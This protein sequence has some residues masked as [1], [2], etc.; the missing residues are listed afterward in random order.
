MAGFAFK[1]TKTLRWALGLSLGV[2]L[3]VLGLVAGAAYRFDGPHGGA[4]RHMRDYGTPYVMALPEERRRAVF[5]DARKGRE[6]KSV[7]RAARRALYQEALTA[8]RAEPF[9]P[10]EARRVLDLQRRHAD[11]SAD[12]SKRVAGR[13]GRDVGTRAFSLCRPSRGNAQARQ[14]GQT[15]RRKASEGRSIGWQLAQAVRARRAGLRGAGLPN[16]RPAR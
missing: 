14:K 3:L 2:N 12:R 8:I 11:R 15:R 9:D 16:A 6:D 1:S 7:S 4:I 10:A 13:V 5:A